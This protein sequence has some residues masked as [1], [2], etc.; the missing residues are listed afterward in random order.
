MALVALFLAIGLL[1]ATGAFTSVS[2][3]RTA[4]VNVAGDGAALLQ[5][6]PYAGPNGY[7]PSGG[8]TQTNSEGYAQLTAGELE[9]NLLGDFDDD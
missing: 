4:E 3:T 8:G 6:Q 1:T 2:A 5:L 9:I 7:N